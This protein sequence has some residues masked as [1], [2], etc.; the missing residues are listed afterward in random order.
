MALPEKFKL[1]YT[2]SFGTT[3]ADPNPNLFHGSACR[4]EILV[5]GLP[6]PSGE[7]V[8]VVLEASFNQ[9]AYNYGT[10]RFVVRNQ[11]NAAYCSGVSAGSHELTIF[12]SPNGGAATNCKTGDSSRWTLAVEEVSNLNKR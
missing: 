8:F 3:T 12:V 6:C 11:T 4:W 9:V 10:K 2:D 7:V 1:E 5:D